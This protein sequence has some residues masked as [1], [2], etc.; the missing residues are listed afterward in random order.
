M[1]LIFPR[2]AHNHIKQGY[3][4]TDLATLSTICSRVD[5]D[6][7]AIRGCD[8]CCGEGAAMLHLVGHLSRNGTKVEACCIEIDQDR[9]DQARHVLSPFGATVVHADM[10]DVLAPR[11]SFN[12]LFLNPPYGDTLNTA[13]A[14]QRGNS[15]R[16]EKLFCRQWFQTLQVGG[17]L[18][19]VVPFYVLDE[20]LSTLIA[21]NFDRLSVR[22]AP[23][24]E[25]RQAVIIGVKRRPAHPPAELVRQMVGFAAGQQEAIELDDT[26]VYLVPEVPELEFSFTLVR[27]DPRQLGQEIAGRM[28]NSTLWPRYRQIFRSGQIQAHRRPLCP[29][30][31]WHL[32][33]ALAA[34]QISGLVSCDNRILLV[35]GATFKR[36]E[37]SREFDHR[38]DGSVLQ[39]TVA[40]DRFVPVIKA[41]DLTPDTPLFGSILTIR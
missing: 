3:F 5:T 36:K 12:L 8:P 20:E 15:D 32:A 37:I 31:Q 25:F 4:P 27:L 21:R 23:A 17:I 19:L 28:A 13:E 14:F 10:A 2:V 11:G 30:S 34:G 35:K 39:T 7:G 22:K 1:A 6:A 40:I 9:S 41:I 16:H 38:P 29:L 33:L 18:I 26:G 24:Q